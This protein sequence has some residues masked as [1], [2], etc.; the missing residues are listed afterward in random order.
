MKEGRFSRWRKKKEKKNWMGRVRSYGK[1]REKGRD[2][3]REKRDKKR[4]RY[5]YK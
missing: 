2:R 5:D 1:N 3:G 4:G